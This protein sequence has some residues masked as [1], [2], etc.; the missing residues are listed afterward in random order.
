MDFF[1]RELAKIISSDANRQEK[2]CLAESKKH[3]ILCLFIIIG[4]SIASF[5]ELLLKIDVLPQFPHLRMDRIPFFLGSFRL[6]YFMHLFTGSKIS[7]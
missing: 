1:F 2:K 6:C 3:Q 4:S 7:T 5:D